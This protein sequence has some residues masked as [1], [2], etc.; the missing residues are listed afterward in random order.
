MAT[1][2]EAGVFCSSPLKQLAGACPILSLLIHLGLQG[3][4]LGAGGLAQN[5]LVHS[6]IVWY[7]TP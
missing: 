2:Q 5:G 4:I 6:G 7:P 3:C 1:E